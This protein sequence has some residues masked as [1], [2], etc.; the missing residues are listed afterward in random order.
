MPETGSFSNHGQLLINAM[1]VN[2]K[3]KDQ[4]IDLVEY[5]RNMLQHA[6]AGNWDKVIEAEALRRD[7]FESF[8]SLPGIQQLPDLATATQEMLSINQSLEKL[9]LSAKK[10]ATTEAVSINKGRRAVSA[11]SMNIR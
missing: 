4:L 5:N 6:E 7:M 11:Y 3:L 1:T 9:A 8:Y 10:V 2:G